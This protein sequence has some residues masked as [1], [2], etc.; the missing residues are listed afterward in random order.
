MFIYRIKRNGVHHDY[1]IEYNS[2]ADALKWYKE[3]GKELAKLSNRNLILFN[4]SLRY[5]NGASD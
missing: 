4:N 1:S 5:R 2:K 3:Q